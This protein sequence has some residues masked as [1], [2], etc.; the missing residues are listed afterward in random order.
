M[1]IRTK[2]APDKQQEEIKKIAVF[3]KNNRL[4][5][6][7]QHRRVTMYSFLT[8]GLLPPVLIL[9]LGLVL[10]WVLRGFRRT[11]LQA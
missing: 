11:K 3:L 8:G 2:L 5:T 9:G 7:D 1:F 10:A 6:I 4:E